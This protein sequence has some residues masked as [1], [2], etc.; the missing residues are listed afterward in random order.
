MSKTTLRVECLEGNHAAIKNISCPQ[1]L[2][3]ALEGAC[4]GGHLD[5][6]RKIPLQPHIQFKNAIL[7]AYNANH[8]NIVQY[9]LEFCHVEDTFELLQNILVD[10]KH[11]ELLSAIMGKFYENSFKNS[12][13][14][15][16]WA[17]EHN[18]ASLASIAIETRKKTPVPPEIQSHEDNWFVA[19][20]IRKS[21]N[22]VQSLAVE[23]DF[24]KLRQ[25]FVNASRVGCLQIVKFLHENFNGRYDR[26]TFEVAL[27]NATNS[28]RLEVVKWLFQVIRDPPVRKFSNLKGKM[29]Y[30]YV[31]NIRKFNLYDWFRRVSWDTIEKV[32]GCGCNLYVIPSTLAPFE[33][34]FT[35]EEWFDTCVKCPALALSTFQTRT[36][37]YRRL[38]NVLRHF[39]CDDICEFSCHFI[40]FYLKGF[41]F[42]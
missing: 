14:L 32:I 5:L 24:L 11:K 2:Q 42:K 25:G 35:D 20:C 4:A 38:H 8:I 39:V 15:L 41:E 29:L 3:S 22:V 17:S 36:N 16:F 7:S 26:E 1:Q 21:I 40:G 30:L 18:F 6:V 10:G 31:R 34:K 27:E 23:V 19:A 9:L 33:Q 37:R 13:Q 12:N 28:D